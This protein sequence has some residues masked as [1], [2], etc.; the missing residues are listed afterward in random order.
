MISDRMDTTKELVCVC[1]FYSY[2]HNREA[3]VPNIR[4]YNRQREERNESGSKGRTEEDG[5]GR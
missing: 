3:F 5:D 2:I 4:L 1:I